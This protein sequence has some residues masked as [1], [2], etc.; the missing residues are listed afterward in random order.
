[1]DGTRLIGFM[2]SSPDGLANGGSEATILQSLRLWGRAQRRRRMVRDLEQFL[3]SRIG[4]WPRKSGRNVRAQIS[5]EA[6][7]AFASN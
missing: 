7:D 2:E 3:A 4:G 1:M 6:R 5:A